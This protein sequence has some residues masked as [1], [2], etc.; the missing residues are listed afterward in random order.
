MLALSRIVEWMVHPGLADPAYGDDFNRSLDREI[1][2]ANL[3]SPEL[4]SS[5][6]SLG[7]RIAG[8]EDL[9]TPT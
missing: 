2:F 3:R 1:E 4:R 7:Y 8:W 5:V 6:L 9:Q